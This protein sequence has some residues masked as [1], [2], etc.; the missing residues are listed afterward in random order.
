M[1]SI[2]SYHVAHS[3]LVDGHTYTT[4]VLSFCPVHLT[5]KAIIC[6][7]LSHLSPSLSLLPAGESESPLDV[8]EMIFVFSH[9]DFQVTGTGICVCVY[10]CVYVCVCV[11][12]YIYTSLS[13]SFSLSFCLCF[14]VPVS[15]CLCLC[16]CLSFSLSL[17]TCWGV[18]IHMCV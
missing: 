2:F 15:L 5:L 6:R 12:I 4:R 10:V 9:M 18:H 14:S 1:F 11:H 8:K 3:S 16:L 17:C 13:L 7:H